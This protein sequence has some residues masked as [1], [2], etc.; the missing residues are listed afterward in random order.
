MIFDPKCKCCCS[1]QL[2]VFIVLIW[3]PS[4]NMYGHIFIEVIS[5][6]DTGKNAMEH[7][8]SKRI[9]P[10]YLEPRKKPKPIVKT[11]SWFWIRTEK[12]TLSIWVI[13]SFCCCRTF[14]QLITPCL[15]DSLSILHPNRNN[16]SI[17]ENIFF[18]YALFL[19]SSCMITET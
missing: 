19:H 6:Q 7:K 2:I 1:E 15:S 3:T 18:V 13:P 11:T 17:F 12:Q 10:P 5:I 8:K 14:C 16:S 4:N 9:S